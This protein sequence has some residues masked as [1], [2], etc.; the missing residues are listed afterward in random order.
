MA[1]RALAIMMT[2]ALAGGAIASQ[3]RAQ[4]ADQP[5][6]PFNLQSI[7]AAPTWST[8]ITLSAPS[9]TLS[10]WICLDAPRSGT[11][12]VLA[13]ETGEPLRLIAEDGHLA[14]RLG[15]ANARASAAI[16]PGQWHRVTIRAVRGQASLTL[17]KA[18]P[19]ALG[20]ALPTRL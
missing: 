12:L 18:A 15:Q 1:T 3:V 4:A 19:V 9:W 10:G 20:A 17:D 2:T 8:P 13:G 5:I 16:A 7:A 6:G 14:L 11:L